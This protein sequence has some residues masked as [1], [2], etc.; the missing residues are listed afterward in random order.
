MFYALT[1]I[2]LATLI[3]VSIIYAWTEPTASPPGDNVSAPI[4]V[5]P[6]LQYKSGVLGVGGLQTDGSTYLAVNSGNVGIQLLL[7][8]G[9]AVVLGL[10]LPQSR[11]SDATN[12][13]RG[14]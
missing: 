9:E 1:V 10:V 3:V 8:A 7:T 5:G 2:S 13:Y 4:N 11:K 6:T 14:K 12:L